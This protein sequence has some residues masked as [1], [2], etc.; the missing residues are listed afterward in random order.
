MYGRFMVE[1]KLNVR[2]AYGHDDDAQ[3]VTKELYDAF[4][5]PFEEGAEGV[6]ESDNSDGVLV[7]D[8]APCF[9]DVD[10]D[11]VSADFIGKKWLVLVDLHG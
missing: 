3:V 6:H 5:K 4:L 8:E 9:L 11:T 2:R 7:L 1:G 10:Y